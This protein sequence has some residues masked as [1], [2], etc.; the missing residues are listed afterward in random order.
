MKK[1][2]FAGANPFEICI[3]NFA[4]KN[5]EVLYDTLPSEEFLIEETPSFIETPMGYMLRTMH[6]NVETIEFV[7]KMLEK[8]YNLH[9]NEKSQRVG[10]IKNQT[11]E[12]LLCLGLNQNFNQH[13]QNL[14]LLLRN[15]GASLFHQATRERDTGILVS[16]SLPEGLIFF[17]QEGIIHPEDFPQFHPIDQDTYYTYTITLNNVFAQYI[18]FMTIGTTITSKHMKI[19]MKK[20]SK[21]KELKVSKFQKQI[22]L[23][24]FEPKNEQN[25]FLNSALA[26]KMSQIKK[27][28]GIYF[29]I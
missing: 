24:S 5:L 22:F 17:I 3:H 28:G 8:Y 14:V 26:S 15:K 6:Q 27:N 13:C 21:H 11:M 2:Y 19:L 29:L 7:Q 4:L 20:Y 1:T 12:P 23:F 16:K 25:C 18:N 9:T 10:N